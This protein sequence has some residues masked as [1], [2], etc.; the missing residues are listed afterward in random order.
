MSL[1]S[2]L[3]PAGTLINDDEPVFM[4]VRVPYYFIF[5]SYFILFQQIRVQRYIP[6]VTSG[7]HWRVRFQGIFSLFF[8]SL[9]LY[10]PSFRMGGVKY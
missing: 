9:F 7:S 1:D 5:G 6:R 8:I 3:L 4:Y 10:L 2:H